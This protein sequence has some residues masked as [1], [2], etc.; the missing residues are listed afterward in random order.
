MS[1]NVENER[2]NGNA[3]E[4][5]EFSRFFMGGEMNLTLGNWLET[6]IIFL[7]RI[8]YVYRVTNY[9]MSIFHFF[10]EYFSI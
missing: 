6:L 9:K 7:D 3:C 8:H 1:N 2:K 4:I 10:S 5:I